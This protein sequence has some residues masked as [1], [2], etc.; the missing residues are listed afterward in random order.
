MIIRLGYQVAA[1]V[2][3]QER[4]ATGDSAGTERVI[5][6]DLTQLTP[7]DRTILLDAATIGYC[8]KNYEIM[9]QNYSVETG[10][11]VYHYDWLEQSHVLTPDEGLQ[12][13]RKMW[14][15]G[16]QLLE[17]YA[18]EQTARAAAEHESS[19]RVA[20]AIVLWLQSPRENLPKFDN[21]TRAEREKIFRNGSVCDRLTEWT[22]ADDRR[23][24]ETVEA[25]RQRKT[26]Q[27]ALWVKNHGAPSQQERLAVGL[28]PEDEV[29]NAMR[30]TAFAPVGLPLYTLL[31]TRDLECDCDRAEYDSEDAASATKA[32]Y[33]ALKLVKSRLPATAEVTL[34]THTAACESCETKTTRTGIMAVIKV[35]EFEFRREFGVTG[36]AADLEQPEG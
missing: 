12:A 10:K 22:E 30:D 4:I 15:S 7:N 25:A 2:V 36:G 17:K 13:V 31:T 8:G 9:L 18:A 14:D 28:L 23:H 32:E 11:L 21:L 19:E 20:R 35:G 1:E 5:E 34:R 6:Y 3:K 26:E 29:V 27:I 24:R 16:K 33:E